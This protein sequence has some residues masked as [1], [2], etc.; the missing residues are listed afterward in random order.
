MSVHYKATDVQ[1]VVNSSHIGTS[2][3]DEKGT[4]DDESEESEGCCCPHTSD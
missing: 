1:Q 2:S 4:V 3:D